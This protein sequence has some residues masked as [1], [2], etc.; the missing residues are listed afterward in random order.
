MNSDGE[1]RR[2]R[3]ARRSPISRSVP[4]SGRAAAI[5]PA[6]SPSEMILIRAPVSRTAAISSTVA[7]T[8]QDADGQIGHRR[9]LGLGHLSDVLADTGAAMSMTSAASGPTAILSM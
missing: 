2:H 8:V 3:A 1:F 4:D 6:T 5:A 7:R 9:L